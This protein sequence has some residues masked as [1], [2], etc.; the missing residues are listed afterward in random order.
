MT[1]STFDTPGTREVHKTTCRSQQAPFLPCKRISL[2]IAV[3]SLLLGVALTCPAILF[4]LALF[5]I[6]PQTQRSHLEVA[7]F[8]GI[9]I[10][11]HVLLGPLLEEVVYRG[12]F[13]Q[14]A[15]RYLPVWVAIVLSSAVF[16]ITHL[17]RGLGT[18]ALAFPIG[19][20]Y[21][22][23]VMRSGSLYPGFL[24][25]S[26]LNFTAMF[27]VSPLFGIGEKVLT[28][29]PHTKFPLT[30]IFPAWWIVLSLFMALTSF[31]M[32]A[33]EFTRRENVADRGARIAANVT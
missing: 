23:M 15:R 9:A 28:L 8:P 13:L 31:T 2:K 33:W 16:A 27:I 21:A 19:C 22:W 18:V 6:S 11:L 29:S 30:E 26:M 10:A 7:L 17:P 25:H 20:L 5:P 3:S 12:L 32:L 1:H 24:C 14:L 4:F